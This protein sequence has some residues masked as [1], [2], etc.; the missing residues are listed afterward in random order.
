M[1]MSKTTR[2]TPKF[3]IHQSDGHINR[4]K[5]GFINSFPYET[6]YV[7]TKEKFIMDGERYTIVTSVGPNRLSRLIDGDISP[8]S[9][10]SWLENL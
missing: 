2:K 6:L 5:H 10:D 9:F 1:I 8:S 7:S 4:R 3:N